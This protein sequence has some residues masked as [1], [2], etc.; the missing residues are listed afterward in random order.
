[1]T[2]AKALCTVCA[3]VALLAGAAFAANANS[4]G[5]GQIV[6]RVNQIGYDVAGGKVAFAMTQRP[7]RRLRFVVLRLGG[8]AALRSNSTRSCGRWNRRWRGC[9]VID[10]SALRNPG[11]YVIRVGSSTSPP[12]RI[13]PGAKLYG[14]LTTRAVQFLQA[15]RDGSDVIAGPLHRRPAH[16][17]DA[18][19]LVYTAPPYRGGQL[20]GPLRDTGATVDLAGGWFDAGDYLK[21]T[22]TASFTDILLLF[23]LR[24]YGARLPAAGALA[25]EARFGTDWLL[26]T[27]D[28]QRR[29]LYEQVGIGAGRGDAVL[30]DHDVWRLPQAD[31]RYR[32]R[33]LRFVARRPVFAANS[34]GAAISPNL[35]GREAAAFGLC[36]QV[37][38]A[39][40]PAFAHRC[41][42]AGQTLYDAAATSWSGRLA[43]SVPGEYYADPESVWQD[44]MEL[45][46][47]EL[48]LA[49]LGIH[50]PDLPHNTPADY[51]QPASFWADQYASSPRA[52]QDSLNL[53]DVSSLAD[54]DLYRAMVA[55]GNTTD[56]YTNASDV[57]GDLRDQLRLAAQLARRGP[58]GLADP[59]TPEDTVVHALGY[60][61]AA[62]LYTAI[63][64]RAG[65]E[66]QRLAEHQLNWV[67]GANPW[68]TSF[69]VGAGSR[70]PQCL[71]HQ[72]ANLSGSLTGS[73]PI[74]AG[75][76]VA[77]PA[78]A[79]D[80]GSLGAPD[81]YRRCSA[82]AAEFGLFNGRGFRYL[83]DV[84]SF[85]TSEP[86]D[87]ITALSLLAFAQETAGLR[88]VAPLAIPH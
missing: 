78:G 56:L 20:A 48:Y 45:A 21:F 6:V 2:A 18:S 74:L 15:Q 52:D 4:P 3:T 44:D 46:G 60:A 85:S 71:S 41:L 63:V 49:T 27:W 43:G 66:Y 31:D 87:D 65:G 86:S 37:F 26:R 81:G 24:E 29:V 23:T 70:F 57:L 39:T 35:A 82:H 12:F 33:S 59:A 28:E 72:V 79:S 84:R 75:A 61:A 88:R 30:G 47:T 9:Q 16:L 50:T 36:A 38:R 53:Y 64:G 17:S 19:A 40:D 11:T 22:G 62:R 5:P 8:G 55:S 34:P 7:T 76:V 68:G 10:F 13:G 32:A 58:L 73:P 1:M 51:L 67:L 69:V 80:I 77:G 14:R 83:D 42:V 54:Y 25:R